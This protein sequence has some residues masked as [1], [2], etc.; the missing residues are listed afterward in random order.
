MMIHILSHTHGPVTKKKRKSG[1][2]IKVVCIGAQSHR[3]RERGALRQ[4]LLA[5]G[6]SAELCRGC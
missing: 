6:E 3:R 1:I 5:G 2:S 4:A